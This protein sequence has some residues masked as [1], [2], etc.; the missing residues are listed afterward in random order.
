MTHEA[1]EHERSSVFRERRD[2][3]LEDVS[4]PDYVM[5]DYEALEDASARASAARDGGGTK[6]GAR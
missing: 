1:D 4:I 3:T 5:R 6:K 2:E